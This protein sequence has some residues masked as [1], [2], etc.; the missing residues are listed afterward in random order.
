NIPDGSPAA[1]E[2]LFGPV[3]SL[4]KARDFDEAIGIANSTRFGLGSAIFT[5]ETNE[6]ERAFNEL[7]CGATFVNAITASDP[8]LPFG[9]VKASGHGRELA[10]DGI[11]EFMNLK[12][13]SI[14]ASS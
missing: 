3:A 2:E 12:T 14:G 11:R 1:S 8:R 13:C 9:G 10:Q 4:F 5:N 7:D 6:M